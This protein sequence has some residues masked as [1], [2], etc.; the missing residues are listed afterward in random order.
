M[1]HNSVVSGY[2][3]STGI[4]RFDVLS[5]GPP[6]RGVTAWYQSIGTRVPRA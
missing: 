3:K 4:P 5:T 2:P 6:D 1:G